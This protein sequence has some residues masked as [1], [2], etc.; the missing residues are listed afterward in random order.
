MEES[1]RN[2]RLEKEDRESQYG[3]VYAVS[4]PGMSVV[5]FVVVYSPLFLSCPTYQRRLLYL[6]CFL[7][8][9]LTTKVVIR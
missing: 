7:P 8:L 3:Y 2:L 5:Y 1:L 9:S 6:N 4:G